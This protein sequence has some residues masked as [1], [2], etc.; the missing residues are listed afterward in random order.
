MPKIL[1][2]LFHDTLK[3][4]HYAERQIVKALPKMADAAQSDRLRD[5]FREHCK[6]SETHIERLQKVFELIDQPAGTKT[7]PA[8]EG[9]IKEGEEIMKDFHESAA[10]DAGL[11]AAAQ[12]VEHYEIAR[13]GTLREWAA[14]LGLEDAA[15][16]LDQTLQEESETDELL[17]AIAEESANH[18]AEDRT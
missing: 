3:D 1:D 6:Q 18:H 13:Y 14:Q 7:C 10:L 16:L 11:I 17:T 12:A 8:I 9:M 4:I 5:A 15:R 2:D